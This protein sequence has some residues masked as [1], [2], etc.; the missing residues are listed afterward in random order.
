MAVAGDGT[1]EWSLDLDWIGGL[2]YFWSCSYPIMLFHISAFIFASIGA[3]VVFLLPQQGGG[4]DFR[5]YR[6]TLLLTLYT[7]DTRP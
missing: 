5:R 2:D 3:G 1:E 6:I 7:T 4:L